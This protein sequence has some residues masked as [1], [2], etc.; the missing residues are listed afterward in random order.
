MAVKRNKKSAGQIE[1]ES[2]TAATEMKNQCISS[3]LLAVCPLTQAASLFSKPLN[4]ERVKKGY[5]GKRRTGVGGVGG[6]GWSERK[7]ECNWMAGKETNDPWK[8]HN[9]GRVACLPLSAGLATLWTRSV[10]ASTQSQVLAHTHRHAVLP[11]LDTRS[12]LVRRLSLSL[13]FSFLPWPLNVRSIEPCLLWPLT[14][15]GGNN[16]FK[17]KA[18]VSA[19]LTSSEES[20]GSLKASHPIYGCRPYLGINY[21]YFFRFPFPFFLFYDWHLFFQNI[22]ILFCFVFS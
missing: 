3:S 13:S 10:K 16:V 11:R 21:L 2:A 7:I 14:G 1:R 12:C 4:D 20:S 6:C 17:N 22:Y 15:T 19:G 8:S 9:D 5:Q 18:I